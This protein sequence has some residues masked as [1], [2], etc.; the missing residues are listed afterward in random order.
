LFKVFLNIPFRIENNQFNHK[1][2]QIYFKTFNKTLL[3]FPT[4]F[5]FVQIS[6]L[7]S[8]KKSQKQLAALQK[9]A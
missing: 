9:R 4:A 7:S 6:A 8:G 1:Q 3:T 2:Q 5:G